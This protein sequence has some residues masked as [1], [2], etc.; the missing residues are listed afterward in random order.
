MVKI[1]SFNVENM[2]R[3]AILLSDGAW[4]GD[5]SGEA[6]KIWAAY[7]ELTGLLQK[8]QYSAADK[9]RMLDL[10][11]AVGLIREGK[12]GKERVEDEAD[13]VVMRRPRGQLVRKPSDGDPEIVAEG[14]GD[15][16]GWLELKRDAVNEVATRNT[17]AVIADVDADV[18]AVVEA[19]DRPALVRFNENVLEL[20]FDGAADPWSYEHVML[21]DGNDDRGIDV[22]LFAKQGHPIT[23]M[24]SHV[25]D[26]DDKGNPVFSRDCPE[27]EV[28]AGEERL[29][30]LVNHFKSKGFGKQEDSNKRRKGQ[31]E[32]V[33][34]IYEQRIDDG[35]EHVAVVGDLN[36]TPDSEPLAPLVEGTTLKDAGQ[37]PSFEWG[38]R[39]GTFGGGNAQIDY[40][41]LS[42][43]LFDLVER[44][45]VNRTG[46]WHG[47]RT[48][49]PWELLPTLKEE[50]Q[51]ASD[52]AAV[53]VE[54][55]L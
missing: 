50:E 31:A 39:K 6:E 34:K 53:W 10:L 38:G 32:A 48:K 12:D 37:H 33:A 17:A 35:W 25:D 21:I 43:K 44:G 2:F 26:P 54:V 49:D 46:V 22:G 42:P 9:A 51:A 27:F 41:L 40:L 15:W 14:R 1:A 36:D 11:R 3:R 7:S 13:F 29:L 8:E 20:G 23:G 24:R 47:N 16:I 4:D 18:L 55:D 52:H 30:I 45:G 28:T 19:E 5:G